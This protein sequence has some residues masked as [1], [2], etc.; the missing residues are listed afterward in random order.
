MRWHN[1][2]EPQ[3]RPQYRSICIGIRRRATLPL[4]KTL[5][6]IQ[7]QRRN[8]MPP[9]NHARSASIRRQLRS[10][11][12]RTSSWEIR[13]RHSSWSHKLHSQLLHYRLPGNL[14]GVGSEG[15][16]HRHHQGGV[17]RRRPLVS[18]LNS[19]GQALPL[20]RSACLP[21]SEHRVEAHSTSKTHV[22]S[23]H[24]VAVRIGDGRRSRPHAEHFA[25]GP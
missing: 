9:I 1:Q 5:I 18:I 24:R 6:S 7:T 17:R 25:L 3:V 21:Q 20:E 4:P 13:Y 22:R 19:R 14:H 23:A 10:A 15:H 11:P 12:A 16:L 8:S 2:D